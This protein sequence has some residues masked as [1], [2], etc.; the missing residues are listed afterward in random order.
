[1]HLPSFCSIKQ[2]I[3]RMDKVNLRTMHISMI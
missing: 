1:M 2:E 3:Q